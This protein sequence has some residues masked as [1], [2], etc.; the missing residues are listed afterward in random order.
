MALASKLAFYFEKRVQLKGIALF[1][2]RRVDV[3]HQSPARF[4]AV[5]HG[6][7]DYQ[8]VLEHHEHELD[9]SCTCPY[10]QD[11]GECKHLWAAVLQADRDGALGA[12]RGRPACCRYRSTTAS[13]RPVLDPH[14]GRPFHPAPQPPPNP[15]VAGTSH[16]HPRGARAQE[17]STL[18]AARFRD[19]LR[20][21]YPGIEIERRDRRGALVAHPQEIR[22]MGRRQGV[23]RH[24]ASQTSLCPIRP[25]PR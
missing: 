3:V 13:V 20:H 9:V 7:M 11:M 2:R 10:F 15:G 16:G 6:A 12:R 18:V 17:D 25:M 22:R 14:S 1:R 19:P 4:E 23:P 24:G 21:R 5:V 8:V